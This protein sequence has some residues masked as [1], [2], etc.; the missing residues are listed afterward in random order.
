MLFRMITPRISKSG[1][2]VHRKGIP[3]PVRAD[4]QRL[5][6]QR[7]E[8]KLTLR[9]GMK[10][11]E[12]KVRISEWTAEIESRIAAIRAA[13]RGEGQSLTLRQALALAGEW[14]VWYVTRHEDNP[15]T[16]EHWRSMWDALIFHL[17]E[18]APDWVNEEGW[19]DLK[20]TREPD[21]RA[22]V[23]PLIAD[24]CKTAQ[25]LASKIVVLNSEAQAAFLDCVLDEFIAAILLLE[26]R[27]NKDYS[28]DTRPSEFPKFDGRKIA[29][30][31]GKTSPWQLFEAWVTARQPAASG[32]NRWRCVFL[33]LEQRF[34]NANDITEDEARDWS[35]QLVT[36]KRK[37]RTVNDVWLT[38]ARTVFAW[39]REERLIATYPF[40][41]MRVT[42]PR[43]IKQRET[44]AFMPE[45]W[46]TILRAAS[47]VG[48]L[49]TNFQ[50]ALRR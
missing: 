35:R 21:V 19:R 3:E 28:P 38:A 8:A 9:A 7:W 10:R 17:E 30:P 42:E 13:Q 48:T 18:H 26:R 34:E 20:W 31:T 41:G 5:Y 22:G 49:K 4:Y 12:A 50:G 32:V 40:E 37:A 33:D 39:A 47:A 45:E 24:E 1:S 2:I 29:R 15:G 23:R 11:Q 36:T 6:G 27:A 44:D 14:Y 25:F 43:R 16:V 46:R